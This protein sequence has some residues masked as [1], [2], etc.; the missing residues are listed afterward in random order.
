MAF[1]FTCFADILK[2]NVSSQ[3]TNVTTEKPQKCTNN[4]TERRQ[5]GISIAINCAY[6][7][8]VA[9]LP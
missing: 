9:V 2:H 1:L 6:D 8:F 4:K 5:V 7:S 3:I